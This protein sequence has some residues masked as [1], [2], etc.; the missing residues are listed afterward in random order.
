MLAWGMIGLLAGILSVPLR[1]YR[2]VLI[3]YGA[4]AGVAYSM[5]MDIWTVLWYA[6]GFKVYL[7]IAALGTALPYTASY[8]VSNVLF[9]LLLAKP[10]GEKL[11]R[12]KIKYGV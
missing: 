11:G 3:I 10:F 1:K 7:Y 6:E 9:L 5:I 4:A 2:P 8:V 12:I